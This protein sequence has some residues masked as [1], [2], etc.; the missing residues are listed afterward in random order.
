M[1]FV[2]ELCYDRG[3]TLPTHF[4]RGGFIGVARITG[5][6]TDSNSPWFEGP[7]GLLISNARP[8][9]FYPYRGLLNLWEVR[10]FE[11]PVDLD[12]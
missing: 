3:I 1:E 11:P 8:I 9:P 10:D 12:G 7:F 2:K 5:C 4:D 6:V